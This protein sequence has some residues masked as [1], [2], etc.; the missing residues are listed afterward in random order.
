MGRNEQ[1][2]SLQEIN[3]KSFLYKIKNFF[4]KLFFKKESVEQSVEQNIVEKDASDKNSTFKKDIKI[5]TN[6]ELIIIQKKLESG[7]MKI[8]E[9]D[10]EKKDELIELYDKQ[11]EMKKQKLANMKQKI[12]NIKKNMKTA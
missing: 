1:E 5:E 6:D 3:E 8:S 2:M 4:R 7:E 11:I 10:E 9:L 12:L